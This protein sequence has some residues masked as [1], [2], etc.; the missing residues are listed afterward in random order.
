MSSSLLNRA[1]VRQHILRVAKLTRPQLGMTRVSAE[2]MDAIEEEL[3]RVIREMV[4]SH[5]SVGKTFK[6]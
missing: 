2:G 4:H 6:P 3:R 1:A 5:P